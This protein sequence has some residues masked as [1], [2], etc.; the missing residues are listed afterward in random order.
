MDGTGQGRPV[1]SACAMG[2]PLE[3]ALAAL[4]EM[5]PPERIDAAVERAG[6]KSL[7][8]R[9]LPADRTVWLM[10]GSAVPPGDAGGRSRR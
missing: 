3:A 2:V 8:R 6:R 4:G 9:R 7:R 1:G 5:I 10:V